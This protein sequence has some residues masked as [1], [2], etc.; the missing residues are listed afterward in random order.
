MDDREWCEKRAAADG[1]PQATT[2]PTAA[3]IEALQARGWTTGEGRLPDGS[4][5]VMIKRGDDR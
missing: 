3:D 1:L 2:T 4:V 5:R